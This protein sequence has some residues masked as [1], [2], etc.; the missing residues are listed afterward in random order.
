MNIF[1]VCFFALTACI[2]VTVLRS[3]SSP[4]VALVSLG[5]CAAVLLTA[6]TVLPGIFGV[7][8]R[9]ASL[10]GV[11]EEYFS[12]LIKALGI[13]YLASVTCEVCKECGQTALASQTVLAGKAAML[14]SCMPLLQEILKAIM[15]LI[16]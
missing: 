4:Y 2:A 11:S 3:V 1:S 15:S 14:L 5:A 12:C 8:Q 6:F 16:E 7:L 10:F 13:S 9:G